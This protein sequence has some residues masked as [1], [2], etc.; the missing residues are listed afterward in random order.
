MSSVDDRIKE[1][2][3]ALADQIP[4]DPPQVSGPMQEHR[5]RRR[6]MGPALLAVAAA[7]AGLFL[8]LSNR[9]GQQSV[10]TVDRSAESCTAGDSGNIYLVS[11]ASNMNATLYQGSLCP[12]KFRALPDLT[13][14]RGVS[15]AGELVVITHEPEG[16][17]IVTSQGTPMPLPV[18]DQ[19]FVDDAAVSPDGMIAY[20]GLQSLKGGEHRD[21]LFTFDPKTGARRPLLADNRFLSKPSWGPGGR[22][23]VYRRAGRVGELPEITIVESDGKTRQIP[24]NPPPLQGHVLNVEW[25]T[26]NVIAVS[27]DILDPNPVMVTLLVEPDTGKQQVLRGWHAVAWS[28]DGTA[29]LLQGEKNLAVTKAPDFRR[30]REL[31]PPPSGVMDGAWLSCAASPCPKAAADVGDP[32]RRDDGRLDLGELQ[33]LAKAGR[34]NTI[35][36]YPRRDEIKGFYLTDNGTRAKYTVRVPQ[37]VDSEVLLEDLMQQGIPV[38]THD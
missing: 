24:I 23:A 35:D 3:T 34:V 27:Y 1:A 7:A 30:F 8:V 26:S 32:P 6:R 36:F 15:G 5:V 9:T 31:G 22:I 13:R 16:V 10:R 17:E 28:P 14:V 25:G 18:P 2:I 29:L 37:S 21:Q 11:G 33:R 20:T 4:A 19:Q 12:L 38:T